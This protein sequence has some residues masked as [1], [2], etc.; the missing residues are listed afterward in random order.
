MLLVL[1]AAELRH[2]VWLEDVIAYVAQTS[3]VLG[4]RISDKFQV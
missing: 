3:D 1:Q 2:S 4:I